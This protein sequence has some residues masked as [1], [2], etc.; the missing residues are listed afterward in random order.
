M[1]D[2]FESQPIDALCALLMMHQKMTFSSLVT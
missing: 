1:K 2:D